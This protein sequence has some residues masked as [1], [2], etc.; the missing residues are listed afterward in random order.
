[1]KKALFIVLMSLIILSS[2]TLV[3]NAIDE[4]NGSVVVS[5]YSEDD[6]LVITKIYLYEKEDLGYIL[7][8]IGEIPNTKSMYLSVKPGEY[9]V[10]IEVYNKKESKL[11]LYDTGY[12]NFQKLEKKDFLEVEFDGKGIFF[13]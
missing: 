8:F 11:D 4:E 13:N 6:D 2:C 1:M 3:E 12:K 7:H 9:S 10:K 5:N